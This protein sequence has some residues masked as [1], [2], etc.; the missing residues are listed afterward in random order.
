MRSFAK[1]I[2]GGRRHISVESDGQLFLRKITFIELMT[3]PWQDHGLVRWHKAR[4]FPPTH[5]MNV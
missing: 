1:T 5:T 4:V 2:A 3:L